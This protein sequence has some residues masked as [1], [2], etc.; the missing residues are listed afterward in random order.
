MT[1]ISVLHPNRKGARFDV[2]YYLDTHMPRSINLLSR[3]PGFKGVAVDRGA[4]GA[5]PPNYTDIQPLIQF[6]DVL[7]S[8][9]RKADT[10]DLRTT[11]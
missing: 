3:H 4:S 5:E 1:K 9:T 8:R 7:L 11:T 6:S 2:R 10:S